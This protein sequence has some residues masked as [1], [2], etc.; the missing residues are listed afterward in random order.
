MLGEEQDELEMLQE[1]AKEEGNDLD[2]VSKARLTVV[3]Q[4][5]K[6]LLSKDN[7]KKYKQTLLATTGFRER[8]PNLT[9]PMT[10]A[11]AARGV[12]HKSQNS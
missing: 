2:A 9:L 11:E 3:Q 4:K 12:G 7:A 5:A 1:V 10:R 6:S 8:V